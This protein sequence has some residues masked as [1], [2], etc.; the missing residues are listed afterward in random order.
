MQKHLSRHFVLL[1]S[2]VCLLGF[3]TKVPAQTALPQGWAKG[4]FETTEHDFGAVSKGAKAEFAFKFKNTLDKDLLITKLQTSCGCTQPSIKQ[5]R[6]RPGE[7]S[8][9]IAKFNTESFTGQ[10]SA[11][12]TVVFREPQMTEVQL[13]VQG[14]I[15]TDVSIDPA[16]VDFGIFRDGDAEPISLK[17]R[18]NGRSD[19]QISDVRSQFSQLQVSI[20]N[21]EP[22]PT[23]VLY[24]MKVGLKPGTPLGRFHERMTL[25]TNES[26]T[27]TITVDV[28]GQVEPDLI[29]TPAS[30]ALGTVKKGDTTTKRLVLRGPKPFAVKSVKCKDLRF[31]FNK[32]AGKNTL[33]FVT[34]E[35][36][37]GQAPGKV[38]ETIEIVT[39]LN[40]GSKAKCR[41]SGEV[42]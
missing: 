8:E 29:L 39:D 25:V 7:Q 36:S 20:E 18:Y 31:K 17:V 10:K 37:S 12:V 38:F 40:D 24:Q 26:A 5:G 35:F 14:F 3:A 33:H 16:Q 15:R 34:V 28:L 27:R 6:I 22:T 30:L 21:R 19:W 42:L 4:M 2:F 41:V 13:Q 11:T 9:V 32:P 23:G 1:A